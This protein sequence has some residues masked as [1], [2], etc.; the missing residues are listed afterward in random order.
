M[1]TENGQVLADVATILSR[2]QDLIDLIVNKPPAGKLVEGISMSHYAC[3][4]GGSLELFLDQAR[5]FFDSKNIA[6]DHESN[7]KRVLAMVV[8]NLRG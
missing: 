7:R 3:E 2:Q 4:L 6:Y 1:E 8:S 5:L